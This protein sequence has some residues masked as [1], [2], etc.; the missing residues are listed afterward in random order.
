MSR[1]Y[2]GNH[3]YDQVLIGLAQGVLIVILLSYVLERDLRK[4]YKN[5]HKHSVLSILVHPTTLWV[6]GLNLLTLYIHK[7]HKKPIPQI[8][9]DNIESRCGVMAGDKK[10]PDRQSIELCILSLGNISNVLGAYYEQTVLKTHVFTRWNQTSLGKRLAR[11]GVNTVTCLFAFISAQ[12]AFKTVF[13]PLIG[14][15][16]VYLWVRAVMFTSGNFVTFGYLRWVCF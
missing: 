2:V 12:I 7:Q 16:Q 10:N 3:T 9:V 14:E 15:K 8:W 1:V 5:L 4:W 6:V 13:K 11:I